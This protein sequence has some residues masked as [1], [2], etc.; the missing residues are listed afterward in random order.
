MSSPHS[1][2]QLCILPHTNR[3]PS[4]PPSPTP[5]NI[6]NIKPL[7]KS[8]LPPL[9]RPRASRQQSPTPLQTPHQLLIQILW[10]LH[11]LHIRLFQLSWPWWRPRLTLE[12]HFD[13]ARGICAIGRGDRRGEEEIWGEDPEEEGGCRYGCGRG[14]GDRGVDVEF[15]EAGILD[16]EEEAGGDPFLGGVGSWCRARGGCG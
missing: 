10:P 3:F 6:P 8:H 12:E 4:L 9:K 7:Q 1:S 16:E 2:D 11:I 13:G 5:P 14:N 15:S